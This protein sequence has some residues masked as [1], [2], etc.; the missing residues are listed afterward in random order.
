MPNRVGQ[1][2][3]IQYFSC[4]ILTECDLDVDVPCFSYWVQGVFFEDFYA[5]VAAI[6]SL[7]LH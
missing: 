1:T 5:H 7:S 4:V 3:L 2:S 6:E